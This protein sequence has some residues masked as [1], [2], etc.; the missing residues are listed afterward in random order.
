VTLRFDS[1]DD[2]PDHLRRQIEHRD[3]RPALDVPEPALSEKQWQS[4]VVAYAKA[5]GWHVMHQHDS[6]RSEPGWPDLTLIRPPVLVFA[7]LKA[8]D[9]K[10]RKEQPHVMGLLRACGLPVFLW[11]PSQWPDVQRELA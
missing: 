8:E 3:R 7:E 10:L 2:M 5:H 6:R 4:K 11:R 1:L 9:G